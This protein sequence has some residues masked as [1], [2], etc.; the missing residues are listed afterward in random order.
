MPPFSRSD[1]M[2]NSNTWEQGSHIVSHQ[3]WTN[4]D[5]RVGDTITEWLM[6]TDHWTDPDQTRCENLASCL[7]ND[8]MLCRKQTN[9]GNTDLEPTGRNT[10]L[11]LVS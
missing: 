3:E 11:T 2:T 6:A 10:G 9:P 7:G 5:F 1:I 4:S 8:P